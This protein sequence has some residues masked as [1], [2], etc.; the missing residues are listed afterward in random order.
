[1]FVGGVYFACEYRSHFTSMEKEENYEEHHLQPKCVPRQDS[2]VPTNIH[3]LHVQ[4]LRNIMAF[5]LVE[6][7]N[8]E[9]VGDETDVIHPLPVDRDSESGHEKS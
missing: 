3:V 9:R 4:V 1:M 8:F 6:N 5:V 7:H 2:H